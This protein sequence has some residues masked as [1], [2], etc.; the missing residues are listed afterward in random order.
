MMSQPVQRPQA[1]AGK[2]SY[3]DNFED[4][5]LRHH[6]LRRATSNPTPAEMA[7]Y[8]QI[9]KHFAHNTLCTY[10]GLLRITGF[11][12]GDVVATAQVHLVSYLGCFSLE[13]MP[14]KRK[15]FVAAFVKAKGHEPGCDDYED[16]N[17]ADFTA[18]LKQ[19]MEDLVRVCRQK[20]RNINGQPLDGVVAFYGTPEPF[21][22]LSRL[23]T[24][25][26]SLGYHK[27]DL[28]VFKTIRRRAKA[29][30]SECFEFD[31]KWYV[32]CRQQTKMLDAVDFA[33]ADCSPYDNLHNMGPE[34]Y[35][36]QFEAA[37][38]WEAR[39]REFEASSIGKRTETLKLFVAANKD[40]PE[41]KVEIRV[42][43]KMLKALER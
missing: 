5:Y 24:D 22:F 23:L 32:C 21:G 4:C 11:G 8:L 3:R 26:D 29:G 17:K 28:A 43:E 31:G 40:R 14:T 15:N 42:A 6:Y 27:I 37:N 19:R 2:I 36:Q 13:A 25:Y 9:C 41:F 39:V 38:E 20:V 18:F 1:A 35:Y 7:P 16:K 30:R 12:L 10:A 34:D 33:G